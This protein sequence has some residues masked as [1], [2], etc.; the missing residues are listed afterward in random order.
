VKRG[1][2]DA[3]IEAGSI[4][5]I[6]RHDVQS[7]GTIADKSA[8]DSSESPPCQKFVTQPTPSS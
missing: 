2:R 3:V 6:V 4:D 1:R 5:T 7:H 8:P